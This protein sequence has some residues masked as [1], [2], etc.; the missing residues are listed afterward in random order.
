MGVL[1]GGDDLLANIKLQDE[2]GDVESPLY[3]ADFHGSTEVVRSLLRITYTVSMLQ[4][5]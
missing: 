5:Q 4:G 1:V 3:E 2:D